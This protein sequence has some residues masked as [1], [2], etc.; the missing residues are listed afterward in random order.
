[1]NGPYGLERE[2]STFARPVPMLNTETLTAA[3]AVFSSPETSPNNRN[4]ILR[5]GVELEPGE[6]AWTT[7]LHGVLSPDEARAFAA[8]II[9]AADACTEPVMGRWSNDA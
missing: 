9:A 5:A 1:M 2:P 6:R 3:R 8:E 7:I 4:V